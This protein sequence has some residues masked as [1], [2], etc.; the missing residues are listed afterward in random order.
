MRK[1]NNDV[2]EEK[3]DGG[4]IITYTIEGVNIST[5]GSWNEAVVA[6]LEATSP[7]ATHFLALYDL[8]NKGVAMPFLVLNN[9]RIYNVG[10]TPMGQRRVSRVLS[11]RPNLKV[12]LALL[13]SLAMSGRIAINK[14]ESLDFGDNPVVSRVF[15][16]REAALEWLREAY[17]IG[18]G[19]A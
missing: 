18:D 6:A 16:E 10:V 3:L 17:M 11:N 1:I 5:L 4:K 14:G 13:V 12:R 19:E 9:Y 2:F 15:F 7:D 8:S